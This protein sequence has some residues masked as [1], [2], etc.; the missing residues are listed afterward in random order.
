MTPLEGGA[1]AFV[2]VVVTLKAPTALSLP[3]GVAITRTHSAMDKLPLPVGH[4][5]ADKIYAAFARLSP[6]KVLKG[7]VAAVTPPHAVAGLGA[8]GVATPVDAVVNPR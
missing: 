8:E 4:T 1:Q 5:S 7:T 3:M 6:E 2:P